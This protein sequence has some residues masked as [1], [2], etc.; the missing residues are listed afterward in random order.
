[1]LS[2][3]ELEEQAQGERQKS[4]KCPSALTRWVR[5]CY[6]VERPFAWRMEDVT[7]TL[8]RKLEHQGIT[9]YKG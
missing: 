9:S 4:I 6:Q 8:A 5:V 3:F 2:E 7:K 1:M